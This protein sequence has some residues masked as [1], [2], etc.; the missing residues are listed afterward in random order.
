MNINAVSSMLSVNRLIQALC[1]VI[2][3][4][5]NRPSWSCQQIT[6]SA[7][8]MLGG[9]C[10]SIAPP[11]SFRLINRWSCWWTRLIVAGDWA[12]S[13]LRMRNGRR[14]CGASLSV[15]KRLP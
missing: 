10:K 2:M 14:F 1:G 11:P 6:E 4:L 15:M 5:R 7:L 13:C 12:L 3:F 8:A 9:I